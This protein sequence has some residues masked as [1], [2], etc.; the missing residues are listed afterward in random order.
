[1]TAQEA[2]LKIKAMFAEA[3]AQPQVEVAAAS[4]AEYVLASGAKVM[5]DKLELG[6]KVS[7]VDEMGNEAPAPAGEHMLADGTKIV[8]DETATIVE[9]EAPEVEA[10]EAPVEET[11]V[12]LMKKK[13]AT[14]EAQLEELKKGKADA[15]VKMA[16]NAE[17]FSK[18]INEL[19]DVVIELTKTPSAQPTAPKEAF[20]K[21][22]DS[23]SDKISR[24]LNT[25]AKK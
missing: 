8:L 10:P 12:E 16:E 6:G 15:E 22:F 25:Y 2:L 1:M 21:H 5:I 3:A 9:I 11:E 24:F 14:M 19:T 13:I 4:F 7:L 20:N 23:K 17:K 18:A